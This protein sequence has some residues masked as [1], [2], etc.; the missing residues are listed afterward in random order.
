MADDAAFIQ[1][2]ARIREL[3]YEL[4]ETQDALKASEL[5]RSLLASEVADVTRLRTR[6]T[7]A[8]NRVSELEGLLA[9]PP[10]GR[11]IRHGLYYRTTDA[12]KHKT[13]Q[14]AMLRQD[15]LDLAAA[16]GESEATASWLIAQGWRRPKDNT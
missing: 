1:A 9:P 4:K 2:V 14:D 5:A 11:G 8:N 16:I 15:V 6:L 3:G 13:L 12:A 10:D 7:D